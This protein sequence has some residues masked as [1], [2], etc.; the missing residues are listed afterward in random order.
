MNTALNRW[1]NEK[2]SAA[3]ECWVESYQHKLDLGRAARMVSAR[4]AN[5]LLVKVMLAWQVSAVIDLSSS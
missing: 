4:Y 1:L 3:F 5:G 2:L